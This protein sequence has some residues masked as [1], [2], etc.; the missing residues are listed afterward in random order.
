LI[1]TSSVL[2]RTDLIRKLGGFDETFEFCEDWDLWLRLSREAQVV[3]LHRPMM[4]Y[5]MRRKGSMSLTTRCRSEW[6]RRVA[7]RHRAFASDGAPPVLAKGC[8]ASREASLLGC[9]ADEALARGD[10]MKAALLLSRVLV[11]RPSARSARELGACLLR[12]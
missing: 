4:T 3:C 8:L 12:R 1:G 7:D 5:L 6:I 10:R 9:E 11:L 2:A